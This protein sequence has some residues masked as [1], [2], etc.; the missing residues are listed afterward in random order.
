MSGLQISPT[1]LPR[2][3]VEDVKEED[4]SSMSHATNNWKIVVLDPSPELNWETFFKDDNTTDRCEFLEDIKATLLMK[5]G[6][7]ETHAPENISNT[8]S[9]AESE[10][11]QAE[12][13]AVSIL[14]ENIATT[15]K[16][17]LRFRLDKLK[18]GGNLDIN[19][20]IKNGNSL[21][22][23]ACKTGNSD[24]IDAL[25]EYGADLATINPETRSTPL[26][27]VIESGN[28][29]LIHDVLT[30]SPMAMTQSCDSNEESPF[31][32][33]INHG[34]QQLANEILATQ[35]KTLFASQ[36]KYSI[37]HSKFDEKLSRQRETQHFDTQKQLKKQELELTTKLEKEA[38]KTKKQLVANLRDAWEGSR[39][40]RQQL[41]APAR[42][43]GFHDTQKSEQIAA[44]QTE[45]AQTKAKLM[46]LSQTNSEMI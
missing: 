41:T 28:D 26:H 13:S 2:I 39:R 38:E 44:L 11:Q 43:R 4:S 36:R 33:L 35:T 20:P 21:L 7:S 31:V 5:N 34:K 27:S 10:P 45:L 42:Q 25:I 29:K 1:N 3:R 19:A 12:D 9:I 46:I 22:H 17:E 6:P 30:S 14:F 40:L 16:A 37:L 15:S 32:A 8:P 18:N 24:A 23:Q